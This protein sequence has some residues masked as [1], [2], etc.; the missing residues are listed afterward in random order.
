[1]PRTAPDDDDWT[2]RQR[3]L[4]ARRVRDIRRQQDLTQEELFLSAGISRWA[5]QEI[6]AGRGNPTLVTLLRVAW[7]LNVHVTDLLGS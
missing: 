3:Q 1:M 4:L 6:E 2:D 7:V 5:L